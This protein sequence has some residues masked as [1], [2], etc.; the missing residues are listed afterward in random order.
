M[1]FMDEEIAKLYKNALCFEDL[2]QIHM[3]GN[4]Y[5]SDYKSLQIS[6]DRCS[7]NI[8][9]PGKCASKEDTDKWFKKEVLYM[10]G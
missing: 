1:K 9:Y 4:W 2:S 5:E 8:M 6:I 10:I 3:Y 7:E